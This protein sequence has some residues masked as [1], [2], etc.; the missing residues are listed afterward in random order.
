MNTAG[1]VNHAVIITR[2]WIYDSKY[3][4]SLPLMKYSLDLICSL[5]KDD[6]GVFV[7]FGDF[8]MPLGI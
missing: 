5:S 8:S 7:E 2:F 4:G 6:K 3:K 1:N